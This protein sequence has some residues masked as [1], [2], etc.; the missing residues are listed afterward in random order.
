M[1]E[2]I[3]RAALT[4][5]IEPS[6]TVGRALVDL[7]GADEAH[8]IITERKQLPHLPGFSATGLER[9]RNEWRENAPFRDPERD[10]ETITSLGG[11]FLIPGDDH[12]PAAL[13]DLTDAPLGLW[14]RGDI[15]SGIPEAAACVSITARATPPATAP[16]WLEISPTNSAPEVSASFPDLRTGSTPMHTKAPWRG[17]VNQSPHRFL[18][19]LPWLLA[20]WTETILRETGTWPRQS[21]PRDS[22]CPSCLPVPRL[23]VSASRR[24]TGS[25]RRSLP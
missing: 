9:S 12:W 19:P 3:T 2:R 25:L 16:W 11:G 20:G 23:L 17:V 5:L 10:V 6:D 21:G 18:L 4:R 7:Y 1:N 22:S 8:T 24:E 14:Y 13:N 15:T